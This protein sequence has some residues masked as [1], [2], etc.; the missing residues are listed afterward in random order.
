MEIKWMI[1]GQY[2]CFRISSCVPAFQSWL[3]MVHSNPSQ[4]AQLV[5][6]LSRTPKGC[7]FDPRLGYIQKATNRCF[8]LCLSFSFPLPFLQNQQTYPPMRTEGKL[9]HSTPHIPNDHLFGKLFLIGS[10]YESSHLKG[11][12]KYL[13]N[14]LTSTTWAQHL[15]GNDGR[16]TKEIFK[17]GTKSQVCARLSLIFVSPLIFMTKCPSPDQLIP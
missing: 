17:R 8:S 10:Y 3:L 7:R 9:M 4:V 11:G 12:L 16:N 14:Q 6:A 15:I 1:N 5:G 13:I 2:S